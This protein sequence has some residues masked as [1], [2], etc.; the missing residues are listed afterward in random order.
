MH[1][2]SRP[3]LVCACCQDGVGE[4]ERSSGGAVESRHVSQVGNEARR[5]AHVCDAPS[6]ARGGMREVEPRA[7]ARHRDVEQPALLLELRV[8][9]ERVV[10]RQQALLHADD[11]DRVELEALPPVGRR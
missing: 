8:G 10:V 3:S 11:K 4:C 1:G 2:T 7:R 6:C 9:V 5:L